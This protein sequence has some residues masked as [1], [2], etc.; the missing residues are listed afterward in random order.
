MELT[1]EL[2]QSMI[3]TALSAKE[4]AYAPYSDYHVG[5]AL[6]AK[7]GKVYLGANME[8]VSFGACIC[9]ERV[10][11][12]KA[13]FEGEREF[14][15]LCVAA[16]DD[17]ICVPCGICRQFYSEFCK[18]DMPVICANETGD[19]RLYTFGE[20]FPSPFSSLE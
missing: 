7:S 16:S 12:V 19:Y 4:K 2:I 6:L 20:L 1:K 13:L 15:A 9:A 17:D 5:A 10:A 18:G 14:S 11:I 3:D 8:N